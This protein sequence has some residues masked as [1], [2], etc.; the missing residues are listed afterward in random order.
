MLITHVSACT[1]MPSISVST[2]SVAIPSKSL[3]CWLML[4]WETSL[5]DLMPKTE[6][7]VGRTRHLNKPRY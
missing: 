5:A 4:F 2:P 3:K 6:T 1:M 7:G